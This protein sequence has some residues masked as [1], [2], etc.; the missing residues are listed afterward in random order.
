MTLSARQRGDW[1]RHRIAWGNCVKC[2]AICEETKV[3]GR[4]QFTP[5]LL[6]VGIAPGQSEDAMGVPFVGRSGKLLE[7]C[8]RSA[9]E[10]LGEPVRS[11]FLN[12]VLCRTYEPPNKNRDPSDAEIA[13]CRPRL[14]RAIKIVDPKAVVRLG[15]L[16]QT[17]LTVPLPM[18]DLPHPAYV[19]RGGMK[20]Q[21][22]VV[23]I[24]AAVHAMKGDE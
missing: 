4:G 14:E 5:D 17:T 7:Q 23:A 24:A 9:E 19:L 10:R 18:L 12:L 20:T 2:P 22:Y 11:Y 3:F 15:Q 1:R 13:N 8:I 21:E 16:V 6:F